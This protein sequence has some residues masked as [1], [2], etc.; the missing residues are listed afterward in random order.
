MHTKEK[1]VIENQSLRLRAKEKVYVS[2]LLS[3]SRC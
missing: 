2:F 3:E 1:Q